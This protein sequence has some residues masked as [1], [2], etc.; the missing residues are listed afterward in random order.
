LD[1]GWF[2]QKEGGKGICRIGVYI[3]G[4][5]VCCWPENA[6]VKRAGVLGVRQGKLS[7]FSQYYYSKNFLW[8]IGKEKG[9]FPTSILHNHN[10]TE[11]LRI[12]NHK[13]TPIQSQAFFFSPNNILKNTHVKVK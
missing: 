11:T 4:L 7:I 5:I 8:A 13:M 12:E 6:V 2:H 10:G 9:F 3:C 1:I